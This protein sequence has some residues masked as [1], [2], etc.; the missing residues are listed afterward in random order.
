M[1][2]NMLLSDEASLAEL[3]DIRTGADGVTYPSAG[4]AVRGQYTDLKEDIND[5][6][7][8]INEVENTCVYFDSEGYICFKEAKA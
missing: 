5:T 8:A 3:T 2:F 7:T 6:N 1:I 4:A